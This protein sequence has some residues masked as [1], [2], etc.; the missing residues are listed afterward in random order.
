MTT[1]TTKTTVV[2][3]PIVS[4]GDRLTVMTGGD[5]RTTITSA[6]PSPTSSSGAA[7]AEYCKEKA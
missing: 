7:G 2:M 1:T 6:S 5:G 4:L 3:H